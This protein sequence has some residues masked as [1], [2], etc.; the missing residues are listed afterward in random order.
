MREFEVSEFYD[1]FP[2]AVYPAYKDSRG[3][4][5]LM[6]NSASFCA[7]LDEARV[8][9]QEMIDKYLFRDR[10]QVKIKWLVVKYKVDYTEKPMFS[11]TG[12]LVDAT[13][14]HESYPL[15]RYIIELPKLEGCY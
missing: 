9:I 5:E 10:E 7:N 15:I 1:D 8:S 4:I 6:Q 14:D 11:N 3:E 12:G 13:R 2:H